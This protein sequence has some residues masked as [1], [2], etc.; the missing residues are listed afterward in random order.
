MVAFISAV[1]PVTVVVTSFAILSALAGFSYVYGE[2]S[3]PQIAE[4]RGSFPR[5]IADNHK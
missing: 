3:S 2:S 1:E 4:S 5:D